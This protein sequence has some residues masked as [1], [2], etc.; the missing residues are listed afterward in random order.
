MRGYEGQGEVGVE[1]Q[2]REGGGEGQGEGKGGY[3]LFKFIHRGGGYL[4]VQG[5]GGVG[6]MGDGRQAVSGGRVSALECL[7][8]RSVA[9]KRE[10]PPIHEWMRG[11]EVSTSLLCICC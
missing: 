11:E 7:S 3:Q 8:T 1:G 9:G 5:T 2:L 4:W 6:A 10:V